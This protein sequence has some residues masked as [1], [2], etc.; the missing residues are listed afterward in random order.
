MEKISL[1]II[2]VIFFL[3][4]GCSNT[5]TINPAVANEAP[6]ITD[7]TNSS[8]ASHSTESSNASSVDM[9]L[10]YQYFEFA[11]ENRLDYV[12]FFDEGNPPASSK[13]Y[14]NY[15]FAINLINWG[16][17]KGTMTRDYVE[18]VIHSHFKV[19]NIKHESSPKGWNYDGEKYTAYPEGIKGM[20]I[21]ILQKFKSYLQNGQTVYEIT[22]DSSGFHELLSDSEAMVKVREG[23]VSGN[24]SYLTVFQTEAYKYYLDHRTGDIVFLSHTVVKE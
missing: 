19:E 15:A 2:I 9:A 17:D 22:V 4:T 13:D 12:P 10:R 1:I 20:P 16:D 21:F 14:L 8:I 11:I 5:P 24:L 3:A 6:T 23:I 18:H 7:L